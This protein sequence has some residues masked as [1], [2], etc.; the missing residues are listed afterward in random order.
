MATWRVRSLWVAVAVGGALVGVLACGVGGCAA[1]RPGQQGDLDAD[2]DAPDAEPWLARRSRDTALITHGPTPAADGPLV[3][4]P[5]M[6][7]VHYRSHSAGIELSLLAIVATPR[8]TP[9]TAGTLADRQPAVLL[10]HSGLALTSEHLAWAA[11]FV[12]A[13]MVVMLPAWRG[14]N[15]NPGDFELL[16]GEVDDAKAAGRFL[17]TQPDVD[18]D[19]LYL[20]GHAEGGALAALLALDPDVPFQRIAA[21]SGV[22]TA[23]TFVRWQR[24]DPRTVPFD[25]ASLV[26]LRR[27]ALLPNAGELVQPL[28][29]YV[30]DDD[31]LGARYA[32]RAAERA[33]ALVEVVSV[34]GDG[35]TSVEEALRR[36]LAL[37]V[38]DAGAAPVAATSRPAGASR[39]AP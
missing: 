3:L 34:A 38:K 32:R 17:A 36:F 22:T 24:E 23:A 15:G 39:S 30:G 31:A 11:P 19:H 21:S 20:F 13:G 5:G 2:G 14:E 16:A 33:P 7:R 10:L 25:A 37:V 29:L 6:E 27:R 1:R 26:E 28:L 35:A 12:D 4:Q 9:E 8:R 18:I